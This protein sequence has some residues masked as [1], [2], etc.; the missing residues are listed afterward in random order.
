M[1]DEFTID[2]IG[3]GFPKAGTTW[4]AKCL[5][6]HPQVCMAAGKETQYFHSPIN[7]QEYPGQPKYFFASNYK[8]GIDWLKNKFKQRKSGQILGE[9]SPSYISDSC[10]PALIAEHNKKVKLIFMF[11]NP[12][13]I[14]YSHY[15]Q[16]RQIKP[17]H[18]SF[19]KALKKYSA[20]LKMY[21]PYTNTKKFLDIFPKEQIFFIVFDDLQEKSEEIFRKLC[22]FLGIDDS[23]KPKVLFKK[24]NTRFDIRYPWLRDFVFYLKVLLNINSTIRK[25]S[26]KINL[27]K[28][29]NKI[30]LMNIKKSD[31]QPM[32]H[33]TRQ[34][35]VKYFHDENIKLGK[36]INRDLS[37]WNNE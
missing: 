35:L 4:L 23:F 14:L 2:F 33:D 3:V 28:N 22:Q 1:K 27:F 29:L 36:L 34:F 11:R 13:D 37:G 9:Y 16:I 6:E 30:A 17:F 12:T 19:K 31:Y 32:K 8:K 21:L 24:V 20:F 5:N 10:S 18:G 7:Y 25:I 26:K 15:F